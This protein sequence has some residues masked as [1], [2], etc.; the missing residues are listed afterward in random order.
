[1]DV[2]GILAVIFGGGIIGMFLMGKMGNKF[3]FMKKLKDQFSKQKEG[4]LEEIRKKQNK[5][6][7]DI[8][9]NEKVDKETRD[10]IEERVKKAEEEITEI[11]KEKDIGKIHKSVTSDWND[12]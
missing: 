2:L 7:L 10:K 1:M 9:V 6:R 3:D 8:E 12:I 11:A 4:E 5:I